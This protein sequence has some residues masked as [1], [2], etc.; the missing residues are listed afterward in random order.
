MNIN[1]LRINITFDKVNSGFLVHLS[2]EKN[3]SVSSLVRA[4][5]METLDRREDMYLSKLAENLGQ[6]DSKLYTHEESWK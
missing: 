2:K 5:K 1:K 4:L 3:K 6:L